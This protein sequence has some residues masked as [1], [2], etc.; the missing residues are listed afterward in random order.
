MPDLGARLVSFEIE[1]PDP[2][3]LRDLYGRLNLADPPQVRKG[4]EVRLR[5]MIATAGG[6]KELR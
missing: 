6:V 2:A 3:W 5:A 4:A 1:H